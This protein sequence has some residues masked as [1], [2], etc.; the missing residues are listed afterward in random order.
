MTVIAIM[1]QKGGVAKTTSAVNIGDLLSRKGHKVLICDLDPQGNVAHLLGFDP[2]DDIYSLL[3][4]K[5]S[6]AKAIVQSGR[7][8]LDLVRSYKRTSRIE[9]ASE[10]GMGIFLL[11]EVLENNPRYDVVLIDCAPSV[12]M[13]QT[14]AFAAADYVI[15]PAKLDHLSMIGVEQVL[16]SLKTVKGKVSDC[17]LGGILPTF[18]ERVTNETGAL[19]ENL[20]KVFGEIV[21]PPIPADTQCRVASRAGKTLYEYSPRT[22]ALIGIQTRRGYV[23]G[24]L[25][26]AKRIEELYV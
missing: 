8:N 4:D 19:L 26:T 1:N 17:A 14:M 13:L 15:V 23:G 9:A 22:P 16:Q 12:S 24:Y 25:A 2:Q 18:Y 6:L 21:F 3:V 10:N 11:N 5:V 7:K 20:Y